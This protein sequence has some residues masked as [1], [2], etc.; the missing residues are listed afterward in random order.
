MPGRWILGLRPPHTPLHSLLQCLQWTINVFSSWKCCFKDKSSWPPLLAGWLCVNTPTEQSPS[1]PRQAWAFRS[2]D[3]QGSSHWRAVCPNEGS[4]RWPLS[5][6][7]SADSPP[8]GNSFLV[9]FHSVP[10]S[11]LSKPRDLVNFWLCGRMWQYRVIPC[12]TEPAAQGSGEISRVCQVV[13][14]QAQALQVP[15]P[16]DCNT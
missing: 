8:P 14:F 7:S 13:S 10:S 2:A 16:K 1:H 12:G 15:T 4:L 3:A 9:A 6:S 11:D 5:T